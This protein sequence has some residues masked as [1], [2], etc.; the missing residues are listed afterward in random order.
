MLQST[1]S[2]CSY[3]FLVHVHLLNSENLN[4]R[5]I[6]VWVFPSSLGN[7]FYGSGLILHSWVTGL[8]HSFL[9]W[10]VVVQDQFRGKSSYATA[11]HAF[12]KKSVCL[13]K[14]DPISFLSGM[15]TQLA[16]SKVNCAVPMRNYS[17][18]ALE[19]CWPP[20]QTLLQSLWAVWMSWRFGLLIWP[21]IIS[22]QHVPGSKVIIAVL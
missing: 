3:H 5:S 10:S 11:T 1:L 2:S 8:R 19:W 4:S 17:W 6:L 18:S 22:C 21:V 20:D 9:Q 7:N 12:H 14:F 15:H 16:I 13:S